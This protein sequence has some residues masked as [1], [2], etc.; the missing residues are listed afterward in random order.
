MSVGHGRGSSRQDTRIKIATLFIWIP[1]TKNDID[2]IDTE[3][4]EKWTVDIKKWTVKPT[5]PLQDPVN[6]TG[7]TNTQAHEYNQRIHA[8]TWGLGGG[9]L[10]TCSL[11]IMSGYIL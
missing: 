1:T 5:T 3:F 4:V 9:V 11:G 10:F 8:G 6:G 7:T 2:N